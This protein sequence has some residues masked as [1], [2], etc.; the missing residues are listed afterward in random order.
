MGI[1]VLLMASHVL[2]LKSSELTLERNIT[3]SHSKSVNRFCPFRSLS[4]LSLTHSRFLFLCAV[5]HYACLSFTTWTD[6][7]F[8]NVTLLTCAAENWKVRSVKWG[9]ESSRFHQSKTLS[10]AIFVPFSSSNCNP[11]LLTFHYDVTAKMRP[12]VVRRSRCHSAI[13]SFVRPFKILNLLH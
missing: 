3:F 8:V 13:L 11:D 1:K 5:F 2:R 9:R 10:A 12:L 7:V 6:L 4:R